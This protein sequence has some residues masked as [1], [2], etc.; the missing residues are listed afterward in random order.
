MNIDYERQLDE[1]YSKLNY[2]KLSTTAIV[3]YQAL[4]H[5]AKKAG[6][7]DELS[8]ANTTLMSICNT[9]LKKLQGARNELINKN[10]LIYKQGRNQ[11]SAPKYCIIA[12]YD[13]EKEEK[14]QANGKPK[15]K[16]EVN[17]QV[18]TEG[19][20]KGYIYK[21]R[22]KTRLDLFFNYINSTQ[23]FFEDE[24]NNVGI[25]DKTIIIMQLKRLGIIIEE[26]SIL[27][28][29]TD[30]QLEQTKIFYWIIKEIYFSPYKM[31][32]NSL[33]YNMLCLKFLKAKQ[34][35]CTEEG[36]EVERLVGYIITSLRQEFENK[37]KR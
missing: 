13:I 15:V 12:L 35:T 18:K 11:N 17:T 6:F 24:K 31:F 37:E 3:V 1:F 34:Y 16:T 29:F 10:F 26:E 27:E 23:D 4:L 8:I 22:L 32:L 5:I 28:L 14:G 9:T 36:Y 2:T 21:T 33:T 7:Y 20:A 30:M 19:E 25:K